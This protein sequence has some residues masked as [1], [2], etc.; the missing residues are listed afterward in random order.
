MLELTP[1]N[2]LDYLRST[3]RLG[4]EPATVT[5]LGW[6]VS[7]AVLRVETAKELF[8]LKQSR[9][10]LRTRDLWLSD[11][12]RVYR[13]QE[14]MQVLAPLLPPGV[15]PRVLW[16]DRPNYVFAMSHAPVQA[17]VWK[18]LLL[19]GVIDPQLGFRAGVILGRMHQQTSEQVALIEPFADRTV[20]EQLR[21][22]PF[23]VRIQERCPDVA[24]AVA[25]LIEQ[26]RTVRE[27]LCHGDFSP[28]NLL[29]H[30]NDFTLVDYETGHFGDPTM[31][32]GFFLSHLLLKA[33]KR[34]GDFEKFAEL[35]RGFWRGY[36]HQVRFKSISELAARGI[37]HCGLCV[38]ARILGTSP[39][40]YLK[41]WEERGVARQWGQWILLDRPTVWDD[42]LN[43]PPS[44]R[45]FRVLHNLTTRGLPFD[46]IQK[47]HA[48]EVL[49]S[50]GNPT[51][52]VE[53]HYLGMAIGRASVPSGASTGAHEAKELRDND[54]ERF[55]GK[56]V[57]KA[58]GNVNSILGPALVGQSVASQDEIDARLLNLDGTQ[59]KSRL[60][61]NAIL[62]VSLA[63][64]HAAAAARRVPLWRYLD[65][66][67]IA[68]LPLPMVNLISGGLH[69]GGN[70]DFQDFLMMPI[71]ARTYSEALQMT[72]GVYRTLSEVLRSE[73]HEGVLV[74]DE[75]G[76][77]PRLAS[78]EQAVQLC[79]RAIERAGLVPGKDAGLALDVAS[80][81]FYRD[82]YY[83]LRSTKQERLSRED[84]VQLLCNWVERY[85]ILSI[86]DGMAEDD[87]EGWK[88]L[89]D[90]LGKKVQLIGDDLFVTNPV[91]LQRGINE[92]VANTI[93][94]KVNQIGTLTE[95]FEVL[96]LARSAGYRAVVSARSGET[97]DA[98]LADLAVASGAGQIKIGSVARS[99]RLAK[100][101]QLLRIEEELGSERFWKWQAV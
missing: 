78:N 4:D 60:G 70:L 58:V 93:L 14:V 53:V 17:R 40:D 88:L 86:E 89:T 99:E 73:G 68:I 8:V 100:Y 90:R 48:R 91:R 12:E 18:E 1:E 59:D 83:S 35:T 25:P 32:L 55:G 61:A 64:A 63:C 41:T 54:P 51:L 34:P 38:L 62:G 75:G 16:S 66:E 57:K 65:R 45:N 6:G 30:D 37:A 56:G 42:V 50:R 3:G 77:G 20:F 31:D 10:Q 19:D 101:N 69:A 95:T 49:D 27:A 81:H 96:R 79:L 13:E 43:A 87:W 46:E 47:I 92:K 9:P 5:A 98:W 80:T 94:V 84:M 76:F 44:V 22:M 24:E 33:I 7:N 39:V 36:A 52:E 72:V 71:G 97:E 29:V 26:M 85:P 23:Y 21:V 28:K 2:A 82:G 74:G 15:V 11:I 67:N